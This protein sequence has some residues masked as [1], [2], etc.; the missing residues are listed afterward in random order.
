MN[1][2]NAQPYTDKKIIMQGKFHR[3]LHIG[4]HTC[5]H[6]HTP[7]LT[8]TKRLEALEKARGEPG[9][10]CLGIQQNEQRRVGTQRNPGNPPTNFKSIPKI[11][12]K[13]KK[14]KI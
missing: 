13:T 5:A 6:T 12:R 10:A 3:T 9:D 14:K 2:I 4:K 1:G 11:Q 7:R 8:P